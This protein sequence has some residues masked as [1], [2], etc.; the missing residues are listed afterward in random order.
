MASDAWAEVDGSVQWGENGG[1]LAVGLLVGGVEL[2]L[3]GA[4]VNKEAQDF[5]GGGVGDA[6][7]GAFEVESV[8]D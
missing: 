8:A 6:S 4:G 3:P 7:W 1:I 5:D 2:P